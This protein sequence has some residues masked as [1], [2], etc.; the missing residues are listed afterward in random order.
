MKKSV[1]SVVVMALLAMTLTLIPAKPASAAPLATVVTDVNT[2]GCVSTGTW[3]VSTNSSA[4]NGNHLTSV[5]PGSK[6][7]C[8]YTASAGEVVRPVI[9]NYFTS[10]GNY[11][12]GIVEQDGVVSQWPLRTY[13]SSSQFSI[14]F[15]GLTRGE[16][17]H[18]IS[19]TVQP[20]GA[21]TTFD[22]VQWRR[23]VPPT[24]VPFSCPQLRNDQGFSDGQTGTCIT[25]TTRAGAA[26]SVVSQRAQISGAGVD[27]TEV[28]VKNATN[29]CIAAVGPDGIFRPYS[30]TST[31]DP[32]GVGRLKFINY[33]NTP[34]VSLRTW[35]DF[36]TDPNMDYLPAGASIYWY[37]AVE[38]GSGYG[39]ADDP[40]FATEGTSPPPPNQATAPALTCA[41]TIYPKTSTTSAGTVKVAGV[42]TNE[43][44]YGTDVYS[45]RFPWESDWRNGAAI[46]STDMPPLD[47]MPAGGWVAQCRVVRTVKTGAL[48]SPRWAQ[49]PP[50]SDVQDCKPD[51][52][53]CYVNYRGWESAA[54]IGAGVATATKVATPLSAIN[55]AYLRGIAVDTGS[56]L[57][58]SAPI[59]ESPSLWSKIPG[60]AAVVG[61]GVAG[62]LAGGLL[63]SALDDAIPLDENWLCSN[64]PAYNLANKSKCEERIQAATPL[65]STTQFTNPDG[66]TTTRSAPDQWSTAE[67]IAEALIDPTRP[68]LRTRV[69]TTVE[70]P[71]TSPDGQVKVTPEV[72]TQISTD[73]DNPDA[74]PGDEPDTS[75]EDCPSGLT[76]LLPWKYIQVM[77]CIFIWAFIPTNTDLLTNI[78]G[79]IKTKAPFSWAYETLTFIPGFMSDIASHDSESGCYYLFGEEDVLLPGSHHANSPGINCGT[80]SVTSSLGSWA[81][82]T[83][84]IVF[85]LFL[86]ALGFGMY[87]SVIWAI[88]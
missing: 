35:G 17:T 64:N 27:W 7:T 21:L 81:G 49:T 36:N 42:V 34:I 10:S 60:A 83:R 79:D 11:T 37:E 43:S 3:S 20:N 32:Y 53:S 50:E 74:Q 38:G 45:I 51:D 19:V 75:G 73:A 29:I 14:G 8:T 71:V 88:S 57:V 48:A 77:K 67:S 30:R 47:Q 22:S 80:N 33:P 41:P 6:I 23:A 5:T 65:R 58:K 15:T 24:L 31:G 4:Q 28:K 52:I 26:F 44:P 13:S 76:I 78:W 54:L 62:W 9:R 12:G 1:F 2:T 61:A 82:F 18:S 46:A 16:G 68:A 84:N 40:A 85:V 70:D 59:V 87:R 55:A 72:Q 63:A 69:T 56:T 39:C 25:G 86:V 66:S